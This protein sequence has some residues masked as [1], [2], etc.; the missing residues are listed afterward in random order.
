M[1]VNADTGIHD[2]ELVRLYPRL[3]LRAPILLGL[4]G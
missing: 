3:D 1:L 2:E 4:P